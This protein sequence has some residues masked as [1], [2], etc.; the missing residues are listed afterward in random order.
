MLETPLRQSPAFRPVP[1]PKRRRFS[2]PAATLRDPTEALVKMAREHGDVA[3]FSIG[4][5]EG[6][7]L[8]HPDLIRDL[9]VTNNRNFMKGEGL[10]RAKRVL[11]EGLLTSEGEFHLKQRRMLQPVFLKNRIATYAEAMG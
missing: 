10:Q 7:L 2:S 8:S 9:L 1:G 11:G 5:I 4:P 6:Y 3:R